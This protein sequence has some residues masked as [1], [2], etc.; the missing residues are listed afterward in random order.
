MI[1]KSEIEKATGI[2][3]AMSGEMR[4]RIRLWRSMLCNEQSWVSNRVRGLR[5]PV[6]IVDEFARL[7]L[8]GASVS[9]SGSR[10]GAYIDRVLQQA[11]T[12]A[13]KW[14]RLMCAT[15]GVVLRPVYD[16]HQIRVNYITADKI[17]PISYDDDGRL[18][19]AV[20]LDTYRNGDR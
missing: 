12:D 2:R 19:S 15:G 5:L 7:I 16:G 14:V 11:M 4:D 18:I 8:F 3:I 6:K 9:V 13:K 1:N 10:R 17:Y 20:F